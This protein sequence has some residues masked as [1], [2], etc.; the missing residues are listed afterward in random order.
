MIACSVR[1]PG[2]QG[3]TPASGESADT[4]MAIRQRR[5]FP[6]HTLRSSLFRFRRVRTEGGRDGK[7][8]ALTTVAV[9]VATLYRPLGLAALLASLGEM[10][11]PDGVAVKVVVVDNDA[12]GSARAVV[13]ALAATKPVPVHYA[14]QPVR[15]IPFARNRAVEEAGEVDW[16]AFVDDDEVV[17]PGWLAE[18]LRVAAQHSADVVTGTVLPMFEQA[19]PRWAD[20]GGFFERRRFPTGHRIQF[21]R[22]SN[23]LVAGK[24][25]VGVT[26]PFSEAFRNNGGDDTHF[27]Q[28]VRL[29]GHVI[30]WADDAVVQETVPVSRVNSTW[31]IKREYRRGNTLSLCLRDLEDSWG[32]RAKRVLAAGWHAAN[33]TLALLATPVKGRVALIRGAQR[34]A[35]AGGLLSGLTG[36]I[37]QEYSVVHGR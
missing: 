1:A 21:A 20:K 15:G 37:Y 4:G 34:L 14:I 12:D 8:G 26:Q 6:G 25:L 24:L 36:R 18:L 35:F 16:I 17:D 27:F 31:L 5:P 28:R 30:V 13:D 7:G 32:R 23:A 10:T 19:P 22:T 9:C 2:G 3:Q 33:G 29:S 11:V